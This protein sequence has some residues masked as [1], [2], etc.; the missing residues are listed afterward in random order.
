M[1]GRKMVQRCETWKKGVKRARKG[2]EKKEAWQ[3]EATEG[4]EEGKEAG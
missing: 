2:A 1:A 4:E 3:G